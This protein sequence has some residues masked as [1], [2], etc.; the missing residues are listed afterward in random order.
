M[1]KNLGAKNLLE[2][3][4][5]QKKSIKYLINEFPEKPKNQERSHSFNYLRKQLKEINIDLVKHGENTRLF[6]IEKKLDKLNDDF[7]EMKIKMGTINDTLDTIL[8]ISLSKDDHCPNNQ[9]IK[10][11]NIIKKQ[12]EN[13]IR[14][15]TNANS[16]NAHNNQNN[17]NIQLNNTPIRGMKIKASLNNNNPV[18]YNKYE[19]RKYT[20]AINMN[21]IN[22]SN[23]SRTNINKKLNI[24]N[25]Y[26]D[27]FSSKKSDSRYSNN[28]S[29]RSKNDSIYAINDRGS[30]NY[31]NNK[32][33]INKSFVNPFRMDINNKEDKKK[34]KKYDKNSETSKAPI[35]LR[36]N[37]K[38]K[39]QILYKLLL[40]QSDNSSKSQ[41]GN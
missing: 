20:E 13:I 31:L 36:K 19:Q 6:T 34:P 26:Q 10:I 22:R 15:F 23:T 38:T 30:F 3:R 27:D 21:K 35:G 32:E 37:E 40:E 5:K 18:F 25:S 33:K 8:L 1:R 24:P 11:N 9:K 17:A 4:R 29:K 16:Y 39:K 14:K 12:R 7:G 2:E 28:Q 41:N